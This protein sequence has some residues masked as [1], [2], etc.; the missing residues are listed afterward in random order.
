ML[1]GEPG[2]LERHKP[3]RGFVRDNAGEMLQRTSMF[4]IVPA[5]IL[6]FELTPSTSGCSLNGRLKLRN[7]IRWPVAVYLSFCIGGEFWGALQEAIHRKFELVYLLG[8]II[9]FAM[10]F[11][12]TFFVVRLNRQPEDQMIKALKHVLSDEQT[13][14]V[15]IDLLS[16]SR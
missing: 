13:A 14:S 12:W 2:R 1:I 5:R 3:Y 11:G 16:S 15:V 10:I 4:R 7:I 6:T 9:S 8:P